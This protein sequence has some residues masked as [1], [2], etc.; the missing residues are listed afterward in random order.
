MKTATP[1]KKSPVNKHL[2]Y[3]DYFAII[4]TC[5]N[6]TVLANY[7]ATGLKERR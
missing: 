1:K 4:L 2:C 7:A 3:C 5:S 6:D